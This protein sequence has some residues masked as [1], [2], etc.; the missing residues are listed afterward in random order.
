VSSSGSTGRA[1]VSLIAH[2]LRIQLVVYASTHGR[3]VCFRESF[4]R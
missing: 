3:Q 1:S 4:R 2:F